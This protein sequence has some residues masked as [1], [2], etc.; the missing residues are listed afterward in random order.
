MEGNAMTENERHDEIGRLVLSYAKD[1]QDLSCIKLK[2]TR[3][4][5]TIKDLLDFIESKP[6]SKLLVNQVENARNE[7]GT[8]NLTETLNDFLTICNRRQKHLQTFHENGLR[9]IIK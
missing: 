6:D 9:E 1:G 3:T 4:A 2:L 5:A 7:I 8:I